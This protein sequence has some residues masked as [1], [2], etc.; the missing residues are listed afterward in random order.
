MKGKISLTSLIALLLSPRSTRRSTFLR[1]RSVENPTEHRTGFSFGSDSGA[2]VPRRTRRG[3][4]TSHTHTHRRA[5]IS[6]TRAHL[7]YVRTR[8]SHTQPQE[9]AVA[10]DACVTSRSLDR[11]RH[12]SWRSWPSVPPMRSEQLRYSARV[13]VGV[14]GRMVRFK[15]PLPQHGSY[16]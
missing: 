12:R 8:V 1:V 11:V 7:A 3:C 9:Q 15:N 16:E 2:T 13:T 4:L 6:R 10:R 5:R 14:V